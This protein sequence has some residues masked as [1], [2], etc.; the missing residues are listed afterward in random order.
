M[1]ELQRRCAGHAPAVRAFELANRAYFHVLVREDGTV[2]GRF[3]LV[4]LEAA[5]PYSD[6]GSRS[7]VAGPAGPAE[8]GGRPGTG[9]QRDLAE[10]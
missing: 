7:K 1:P 6:T 5:R 9:Y 2:I 8:P 3:N 10:V 4:E